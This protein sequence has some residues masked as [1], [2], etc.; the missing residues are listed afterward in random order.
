[1]CE[2]TCAYVY[3]HI[4]MCV[5]RA[6]CNSKQFRFGPQ[7]FTVSWFLWIRHWERAQ[8]IDGICGLPLACSQ[9]L[10]GV[11]FFCRLSCGWRI[12]FQV[13]TLTWLVSLSGYWPGAFVPLHKDAWHVVRAQELFFEW[14]LRDLHKQESAQ[15][16][17]FP[18]LLHPENQGASFLWKE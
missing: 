13:G 11:L 4:C 6:W 7:G 17:V 8:L 3:M 12:H 15:T 16:L 5:G 9:V 18:L 2:H 14:Y 1:M 10:A